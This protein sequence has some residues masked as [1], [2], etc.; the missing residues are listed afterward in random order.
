MLIMRYRRLMLCQLPRYWCQILS[1]MQ[2]VNC[3]AR[4]YWPNEAQRPCPYSYLL[5]LR[6]SSSFYIRPSRDNILQ[7]GHLSF[8]QRI[9]HL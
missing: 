7:A 4:F 6:H 8:S 2:I 3:F 5:Y 9:K 1:E